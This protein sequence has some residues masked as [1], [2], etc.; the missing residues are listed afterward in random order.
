MT[1][2]VTTYGLDAPDARRHRRRTWRSVRS[3]SSAHRRAARRAARP[4]SRVDGRRSGR[5]TLNVPGRHNL[6]NALAAVAVGLELGLPFERI[7][8]GLARLPRRRAAVRGAR[9]AERHSGRRRLRPPPDRDRGGARRRARRS[10]RRIVVAFQ[11]HRFTRTAA[12]MDAF[13]PALAGAD[14]IVLTDIYAAGEDPIPGVTLDALAAAIRRS[15]AVPVD[16]VPRARG[17]AG[18]ARADRAA[19]RRRDHARRRIDRHGSRSA[20]R[21]CSRADV[22]RMRR[23]GVVS[24]VAAPADKRFRRAHVKP[25]R[26]RGRWRAR[27]SAAASKYGAAGACSASTALYRGGS[28]VVRRRACSQIDRDRRPRQRAAVERRSAGGAD[29]LRGENIVLDRSDGLARSGCWRRRGCGTRRSGVA[30]VDGR[31]EVSERA[32]IGIGR[33]D[34]ELYLV[35]EHGVVIDEY[36][37]QYADLDLPI[38]DGLTAAGRRPRRTADRR[39]RAELAARLIAALQRRAGR[40]AAAV[41]GRRHAICTTPR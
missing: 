41:A 36:G 6:Q 7:A 5:S 23:S 25:A 27:P 28:A 38:V 10:N 21:R 1:R 26:R 31:S 18:G 15:V 19:R 33:I 16:V 39:A 37:P 11:P 22:R 20:R 29:G 12:L 13:G 40:G 32:P 4:S 9:R 24:P 35:D 3:R 2:R 30:A 8:A 17:R 34:G 14:H